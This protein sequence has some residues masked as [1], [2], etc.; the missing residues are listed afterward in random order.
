M[1]SVRCPVPVLAVVARLNANGYPADCEGVTRKSLSVARGGI[2]HFARNLMMA[3]RLSPNSGVFGSRR[4]TGQ[5]LPRRDLDQQGVLGFGG[6]GSRAVR[7]C[8][9]WFAPYVCTVC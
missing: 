6:P 4:F 7:R 8:F 1:P 2:L 5:P 3:K 9:H